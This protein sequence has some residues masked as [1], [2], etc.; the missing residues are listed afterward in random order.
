M[1]EFNYVPLRRF[2]SLVIS[3]QPLSLIASPSALRFA[4]LRFLAISDFYNSNNYDTEGHIL[5]FDA[6]GNKIGT[7][8]RFTNLGNKQNGIANTFP[9]GILKMQKPGSSDVYIAIARENTVYIVN[10]E[11]GKDGKSV[12]ENR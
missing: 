8:A 10:Y 6:D 7:F 2:A 4:H 5:E 12:G 1:L 9:S 3:I 11:E